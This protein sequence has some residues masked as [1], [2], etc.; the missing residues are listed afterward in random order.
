[1]A[2]LLQFRRFSTLVLK[3][4][5]YLFRSGLQIN[6]LPAVTWNLSKTLSTSNTNF[7]KNSDKSKSLV[8][9]SK[10]HKITEIEEKSENAENLVLVTKK[11]KF[12]CDFEN[13]T[14]SFDKRSALQKHI[15]S[16]HLGL[17]PYKCDICDKAFGRK[18]TLKTHVKT[19]HNNEKPFKCDKCGECFGLK[20]TLER[21]LASKHAEGLNLVACPECDEKFPNENQLNTHVRKFHVKTD[22]Q[23]YRGGTS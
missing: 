19:V 17:K 15:D 22:H 5:S 3:T 11:K 23:V 16:V 18:G 10:N 20:Q 1:M 9:Q 21:H 4:Q 8:I 13:C 6:L 12:P 2:V 7:K 14:K